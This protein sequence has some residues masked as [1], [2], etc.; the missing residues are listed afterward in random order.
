MISRSWLWGKIENWMFRNISE[1]G[2]KLAN[3]NV[4]RSDIWE[5][6][7]VLNEKKQN[8]ISK[9]FEFKLNGIY[10]FYTVLSISEFKD[11]QTVKNCVLIE[12]GKLLTCNLNTS[13]NYFSAAE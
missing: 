3:E 12:I 9:M 10:L 2:D 6:G 7:N 13:N 1:N 8:I 5:F 11:G 4:L